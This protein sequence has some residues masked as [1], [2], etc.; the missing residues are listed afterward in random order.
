[1]ANP[2]VFRG[3]AIVIHDRS[4]LSSPLCIIAATVVGAR[5]FSCKHIALIS[6][7]ATI[8]VY[9]LSLA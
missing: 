7:R 4:L 5:V 8:E 2:P 1:M 9:T 3:Y 6:T